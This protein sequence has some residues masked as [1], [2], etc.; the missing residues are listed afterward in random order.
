MIDSIQST[1]SINGH[2]EENYDVVP[3]HEYRSEDMDKSPSTTRCTTTRMS[4]AAQMK[5]VSEKQ[6]IKSFDNLVHII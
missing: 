3:Y 4:S 5:H 1:Q 6:K 2:W